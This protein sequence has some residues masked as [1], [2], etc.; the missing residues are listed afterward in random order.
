MG[1]GGPAV[2]WWAPRDGV[3]PVDGADVVYSGRQVV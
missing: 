3:R 1:A 2:G